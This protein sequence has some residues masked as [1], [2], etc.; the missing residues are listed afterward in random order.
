MNAW[1]DNKART[2]ARAKMR[3]ISFFVGIFLMLGFS[4]CAVI[5]W[6]MPD[7]ELPDGRRFPRQPQ[8]SV[9]PYYD[10]KP[11][12]I[13][14]SAVY[15]YETIKEGYLGRPYTNYHYVVFWPTGECMFKYGYPHF[16]AHSFYRA[17]MGFFHKDG[18]NIVF[19]TYGGGYTKR[20]GIISSNNIRI[21]QFDC[22]EEDLLN[23]F[24][25]STATNEYYIRHDTKELPWQPDWSPTGMLHQTTNK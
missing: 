12:E 20:S 8:F 4:G 24:Q 19:E 1:N 11:P 21:T 7:Y 22:H 15:L 25:S 5:Q 14:F 6:L 9:T 16:K 23:K 18:S 3:K 2:I 10:S 17:Y 13:D